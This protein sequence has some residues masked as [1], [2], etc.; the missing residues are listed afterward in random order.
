M[1]NNIDRYFRKITPEDAQKLLRPLRQN[2]EHQKKQLALAKS[3]SDSPL[4]RIFRLTPPEKLAEFFRPALKQAWA[5]M[6]SIS[7]KAKALKEKNAPS[8]PEPGDEAQELSRGP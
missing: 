2:I 5:D 4:Y 8:E 1:N 7:T 3:L 6:Q